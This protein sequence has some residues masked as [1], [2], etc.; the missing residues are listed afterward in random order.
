MAKM[1]SDPSFDSKTNPMP[2]D[3]FVPLVEA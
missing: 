1:M 2:F 3:G